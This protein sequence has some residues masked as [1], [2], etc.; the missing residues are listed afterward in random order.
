MNLVARKFSLFL[1]V[2]AICFGLTVGSAFAGGG[3]IE[4][5]KKYVINSPDVC[6]DKMCDETAEQDISSKHKNRH[7]PLSQYNLGIPIS[8]ITCKAHL[9]YV[10]K[11]SNWHPA[12]VKPENVQKLVDMGWAANSEEFENIM[13]ASTTKEEPQF[14]PL[15]EYRDYYPLREGFGMAITTEQIAGEYYLIFNGYGWHGF[16][17]VEITIS[18]ETNEVEF[19]MTQTDPQGVLYVPWKIPDYVTSGW[20]HVYASDGI[21]EY[22]I[23]IPISAQN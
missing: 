6:G 2:S 3:L 19:L 4:F 14:A 15:E 23:D 20:Y 9:E 5:K 10:L 21:H 8:K 17:N 11:L 18:D 1:I 7:T 13:S 22:E 16:H 12:C